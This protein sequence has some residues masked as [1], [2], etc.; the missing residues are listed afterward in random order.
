[1]DSYVVCIVGLEREDPE[2]SDMD[3]DDEL[4]DGE[5]FTLGNEDV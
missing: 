4:R 1:M 5:D 2:P 3:F